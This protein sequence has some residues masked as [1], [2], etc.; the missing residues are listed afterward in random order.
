MIM[1]TFTPA[2]VAMIL[3]G[4]II[5]SVAAIVLVQVTVQQRTLLHLYLQTVDTL[6]QAVRL[7]AAAKVNHEVV[8]GECGAPITNLLRSPHAEACI[9]SVAERLQ[10]SLRE[11][12][13]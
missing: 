5:V 3:S 6:I 2:V 10:V 13:T 1:Y 12:L 9:V 4:I 7:N 8:C 11:K